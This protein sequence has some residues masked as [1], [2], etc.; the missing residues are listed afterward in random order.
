[1]SYV[2]DFVN[3]STVGLESSPVAE[4]LAGLLD[5]AALDTPLGEIFEMARDA[6]GNDAQAGGVPKASTP[7]AAGPGAESVPPG[8]GQ[9]PSPRLEVV[10]PGWHGQV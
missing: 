5:N 6:H 2:V 8:E 7:A 4:A 9:K 1:M 3:V 10:P